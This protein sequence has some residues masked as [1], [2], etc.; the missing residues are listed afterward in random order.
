MNLTVPQQQKGP[1]LSADRDSPFAEFTLSEANV[2]RVTR[3][4]C[5]NG[6]GQFVQIEPA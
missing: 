2:L 3:G 4:E 5:S 6:Q 1:A